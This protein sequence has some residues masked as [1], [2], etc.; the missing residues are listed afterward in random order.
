MEGRALASLFLRLSDKRRPT[1]PFAAGPERAVEGGGPDAGRLD[2]RESEF[3]RRWLPSRY[4]LRGMRR[5]GLAT[6]LALLLLAAAAGARRPEEPFR[7]K[8]FYNNSVHRFHPDLEGR[9]NAVRYGRWRALQIAWTSGINQRLDSEF[10][11]FLRGL[12]V[13]PPR[14]PPEADRIAPGPARDAAP[15]FRALRWGQTLEQQVLDILASADATPALSRDRIERALRLYRREP[16]ALFEP[17]DPADPASTA[18]LLAIAP[19]SSRILA[20]GTKLFA[21]AADGLISSDFSEQRWK[22]RKILADFDPASAPVTPAEALYTAAAPA[23]VSA[24]PST[25]ECLDRL[26]KFRAEVFAALIPGGATPEAGRQRDE[27]LRAVARRYGL[28]A[29]DIGSAE[30]S[31]GR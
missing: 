17:A 7:P 11:D 13:H 20:S 6:C 19:V 24:Y 15:I 29:K 21:L 9:L 2:Q 12:L 5:A 27:R 8:G 22:V 4:L 18:E 31:R 23:V 25:T 28:P 30:G 1:R 3:V 16:Y 10:A 26:A 14:F